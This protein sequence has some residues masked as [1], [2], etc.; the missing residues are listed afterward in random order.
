M[1]AGGEI[2]VS[3]DDIKMQA[4][5][6]RG[7]GR[8]VGLNFVNDAAVDSTGSLTP[9]D[10]FAGFLAYRHFWNERWRTTLDVSVFLA[11]NPPEL[12]DNVNEKAG[13]ASIN[14]LY[15]PDAKVT[16]GIEYTHA[17]RE[18][19]SGADGQFD[20]IQVSA[21]YDFGYKPPE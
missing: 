2:N 1:T 14:L 18:I 21:R 20:R 11:D 15:S 13:S 10:E 16:L 3:S 8:Y 19:K 6:G 9:I 12:P 5:V 7:L 17:I 4:T